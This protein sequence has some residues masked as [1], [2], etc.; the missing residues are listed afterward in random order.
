VAFAW[1]DYLQL[2]R[3]LAQA[4]DEPS[5]RTAVGRAYYAV[6]GTAEER[7]KS[8]GIST[9][10]VKGGWHVKLWAT[11]A[12]SHDVRRQQIGVDGKR[13]HARRVR[14]DYQLVM[15]NPRREAAIAT[16]AAAG[17]IQAIDSL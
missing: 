11:Y 15:N 6:C 17:L 9:A 3:Q 2:A 16:S 10:K 1:R 8:D 7:R 14:A 13:L 12:Q 5:E 4:G